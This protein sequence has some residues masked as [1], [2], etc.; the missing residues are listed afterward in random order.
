MQLLFPAA[1]E[2]WKISGLGTV[3]GAGAKFIEAVFYQQCQKLFPDYRAFFSYLHPTLIKYKSVL[4]HVTIAVRRGS[5]SQTFTQAELEKLL[6]TSGSGRESILSLFKQHGLIAAE[7]VAKHQDENYQLKF[8][9]HP[10]EDF[11]QDQLRRYGEPWETEEIRVLKSDYLWKQVQQLGYL[12]E[13]FEEALIWLQHRR[14]V[15]WEQQKKV[16]RTVVEELD[17]DHIRGSLT[18]LETRVLALQGV[19]DQPLLQEVKNTL[20]EAQKTLAPEQQNEIALARISGDIQKAAERLEIFEGEQ[21]DRLQKELGAIQIKLTQL[22]AGLDAPQLRQIIEGDSD[23]EPEIERQRQVLAKKV[24]GFAK[25]CQTLANSIVLELTDILEL[26]Q[27]VQQVKQS[28]D[29]LGDAKG[30]LQPL[31]IGLE[32]WRIILTRAGA[33][34]SQIK[35]DQERFTRYNDDFVDRVV[36]HFSEN[37]I[38]S[39]QAQELL[40]IPLQQLEAEIKHDRASRREAFELQLSHYEALLREIPVAENSL[41]PLC[42]YDDEDPQGSYEALYSLVAG[43]LQA[44]CDSQISECIALEQDLSFLAGERG[45][46]VPELWRQVSSLQEQLGKL[47]TD[48]PA[49]VRHMVANSDDILQLQSLRAQIE[50]LQQQ[51]RLQLE[52][53]KNLDAEEKWLWEA[54]SSGELTL[55]QLRQKL[56]ETL[57][58]TDIWQVVQKLYRQGYF[59]IILSPRN[60]N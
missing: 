53:D 2:N 3:Q 42:R 15:E 16:I 48:L 39:F 14:Y 10:L 28:L 12:Q 31:V 52:R 38:E 22:T 58:T 26:H 20:G 17:L 49:Q 56:P 24:D 36:V 43:K 25:E 8:T 33:L 13:E 29:A 19:F 21:R 55:S 18:Q 34:R 7:K 57:E 6:E 59:E 11:I 27:H 45:Q 54:F 1:P 35:T 23:L 46:N 9:L 41:K 40:Q 50:E 5:Q 32:Q 4:D 51:I 44:W 37:G 47:K 30:K 60:F